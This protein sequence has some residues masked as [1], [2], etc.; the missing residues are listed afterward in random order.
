MIA[1]RI[2]RMDEIRRKLEKEG[3]N[4]GAFNEEE[5]QDFCSGKQIKAF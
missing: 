1:L 5:Y 2:K 4:V 3:I